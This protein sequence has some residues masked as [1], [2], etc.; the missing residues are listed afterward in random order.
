MAKPPITGAWAREKTVPYA[1]AAVWGTGINRVH[2]YRGPGPP[3]R[4]DAIRGRE[5]EISQPYEAVPDSITSRE[6]WGYTTEDTGFTGVDYDD[7][8]SWE[9]MPADF[10]GTTGQQPP[11]NASGLVR[12][13]FRSL[14][15]GAHRYDQKLA[16][17][18]PTETVSE[19]WLNK[20]KGIPADAKPSDPAQ[21][22]IQSSM[23]QRYLTRTNAASVNRG[24]DEP[25]EDIP[26][27]VTGQRLKVYSGG[28]RHYDMFPFQQDEIPRPFTYRTAGTGRRRDMLPNEQWQID[29]VQRVPPPDP[30]LGPVETALDSEYGYTGEDHLYA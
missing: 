29:P 11:Y 18:L 23:A 9:Q 2:Y 30:E 16:D 24:T 5:G 19:G 12:H 3:A 7:R 28:E 25:R 10:R 26:S 15:G 13:F 22:E 1:G 14:M 21:Y 27:R 17:S 6:L 4:L 8:P 20:P